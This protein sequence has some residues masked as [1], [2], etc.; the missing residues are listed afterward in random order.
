MNTAALVESLRDLIAPRY[1]KAIYA[2]F[3]M[4]AATVGVLIRLSVE[5]VYGVRVDAMQELV[6]WAAPFVALLAAVNTNPPVEPVDPD[7]E[8]DPVSP[9]ADDDLVDDYLGDD[10][11]TEADDTYYGKHAA[12]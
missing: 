6:A 11:W 2:A 8:P 9:D 10:A 1:R 3:L 4:V 5:S 7:P 12:K